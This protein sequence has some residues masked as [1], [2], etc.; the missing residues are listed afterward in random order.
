MSG[1]PAFCRISAMI[2]MPVTP[3]LSRMTVMT[4]M[5]GTPGRL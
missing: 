2:G 5:S 3:E 1:M 4:E